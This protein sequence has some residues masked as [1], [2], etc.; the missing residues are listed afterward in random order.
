MTERSELI[1]GQGDIENGK[2]RIRITVAL[3][4]FSMGLMFATWASRIPDI[5]TALHLND[6]L[7]G[8]ILFA[9]PAAQFMMMTF[10]EFEPEVKGDD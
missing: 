9:L 10:S 8:T 6:A 1:S 7:F 2:R 3:F 5:K 4:Y